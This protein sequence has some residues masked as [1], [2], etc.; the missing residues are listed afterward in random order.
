MVE[1]VLTSPRAYRVSGTALFKALAGGRQMHKEAM[2]EL[3]DRYGVK[4]ERVLAL[5]PGTC[6]QEYWF[7]ANG[8]SLF[9]VD[10]DQHGGV[11][12]RL[13]SLPSALS[14]DPD[15]VTYV[16]GDAR[17]VSGWLDTKFDAI[18]VSGFTP[19]EFHRRDIQVGFRE[20]IAA[21]R[22]F[23][24]IG[25]WPPDKGPLSALCEE[26]VADGLADNGLMILL[27]YMGGAHVIRA[28]NY[29]PALVSQLARLGLVLI[30]VHCLASVCGV[31]LIVAQKST[32]LRRTKA[33]QRALVAKLPLSTMHARTTYAHTPIRVVPGPAQ[34]AAE[35]AD[36]TRKR[37]G[38][39]TADKLEL[40]LG[41]ALN[42][43]APAAKLAYY[44]G[45]YVETEG[46]YL[47]QRKINVEF[48]WGTALRPSARALEQGLVHPSIIADSVPLSKSR[49]DLCFLSF[50]AEDEARSYSPA[51]QKPDARRVFDVKTLPT[52]REGLRPGGMLLYQHRSGGVSLASDKTFTDLLHSE[53]AAAGFE[54]IE[55]YYLHESPTIF[56]FAA[57]MGPGIWKDQ[58]EPYEFRFFAGA[59]VDN[60]AVRFWPRASDPRP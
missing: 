58:P 4:N 28:K 52:I 31:Q 25:T 18:F 13:R 8:N 47:L 42:R 57:S 43:F 56:F 11:E 44:T 54:L 48:G 55:A 45:P 9:L 10:I 53:L 36:I 3:I 40:A 14:M 21:D 41:A 26:V 35:E 6:D 5:G 37:L 17:H 1:E 50:P 39:E 19:D 32:N 23:A 38:P 27:S 22:D 60:R 30:E 24:N 2:C 15:A 29:V 7:Y 34:L 51:G 59:G 12:P 20:R 46:F 16:I 49:Y 33:L